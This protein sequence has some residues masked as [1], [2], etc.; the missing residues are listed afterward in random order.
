M[1]TGLD[2]LLRF[3]RKWIQGKRVAL[4]AH[5]AS[6]DKHLRHALEVL[7]EEAAAKVI[8]LFGPEH[9]IHGQAQD[10]ESVGGS[11]YRGIPVYS[12]YG[13][14]EASLKPSRES[15]KDV[16]VLIC[17]LQD[18]GA[19]YYTF[20]YTIAFCMEVAKETGTKVVVLDRPNPINGHQVEGNLV[21]PGFRSFVGWF[22]LAVRH[23]MTVGELAQ[24]FRHEFDL[25]CDLEVVTMKGWHRRRYMDELDTPWV[26][27][28]PNMPTVDTAVVY[29]GMCLVE[30]TELSEGRGTTR[31]FEFLGAPYVDPEALVRRLREFRL[32]GVRFRPIYFKPGFQ[33][34]A[35]QTCGGAQLHVTRRKAFKSLLTGVAALK[36]AHDLY[37]Q[38]FQFRHR[39]YEF[40]D[41]IPAID[42][43]AGN[44]KLRTQLENGASL[45]EIEASWEDERQ[46][47]LETRKKYLLYT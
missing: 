22:P 13:K 41:Q 43:L 44:A 35:G 8:A 47:F 28:S 33:K 32:P 27:P 24:M 38:E 14:D 40:V 16:E 21:A 7:Q 2:R 6:V 19:R 3:H 5:P 36:A 34:H 12:L 26:L 9:G 4:L 29:P 1:Q 31:P 17:D 42:L 25:K 18:V 45:Q 23:G 46:A 37:P 15:L 30:G 11:T 20:I 39:A 10:M